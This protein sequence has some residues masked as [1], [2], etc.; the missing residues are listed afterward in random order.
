MRITRMMATAVGIATMA[1]VVGTATPA[2]ASPR[3]GTL[4][5][6]EFGLY[7]LPGSTGTVFDLATPDSNFSTDKFPGTNTLVNDNT[8]SYRN[9]DSFWWYV[10]VDAGYNGAHGCVQAGHVGNTS[11]TFTNSISSATFDSVGC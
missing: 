7:F 2:S 6:G 8:E 11:P 1:S 9:L 4:E 10:Y 3:D 5:T